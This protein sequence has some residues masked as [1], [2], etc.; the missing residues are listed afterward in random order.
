MALLFGGGHRLQRWL[1]FMW[2]LLVD[3][4][5]LDEVASLVAAPPRLTSIRFDTRPCCTVA[6]SHGMPERLVKKKEKRIGA[7]TDGRGRRRK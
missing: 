2:L 3:S 5:D 7:K 1:A 4:D 6:P